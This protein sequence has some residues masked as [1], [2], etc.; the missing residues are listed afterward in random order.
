MNFQGGLTLH[1]MEIPRLNQKVT[2]LILGNCNT[3]LSGFVSLF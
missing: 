3:P 1:V 2:T